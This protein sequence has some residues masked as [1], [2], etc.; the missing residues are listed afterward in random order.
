MA[1]LESAP[2]GN[3][4]KLFQD[5]LGTGVN[6]YVQSHSVFGFSD[7]FADGSRAQLAPTVK[8]IKQKIEIIGQLN[9]SDLCPK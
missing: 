9:A 4:V 5:Q 8:S 7:I 2:I 3:P 6:T 1:R